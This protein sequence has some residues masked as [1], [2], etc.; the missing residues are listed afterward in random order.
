[1][2]QRRHPI[3]RRTRVKPM[4]DTRRLQADIY[5][6]RRQEFLRDHPICEAVI[7]HTD[8]CSMRSVDVHHKAGRIG[9][10]FLDTS[11]WM[12]ACR[13]CHDWIHQHPGQARA[14]GLLK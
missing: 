10:N 4:S 3:E 9:K 8:I 5:S 14:L 7:P 12:A 6:T 1:V 11:T 13:D 2:I